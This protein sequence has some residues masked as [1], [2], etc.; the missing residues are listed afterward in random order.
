MATK[1]YAVTGIL[2]NGDDTFTTVPGLVLTR[3]EVRAAIIGGP[4]LTD[5]QMALGGWDHLV[6]AEC[7]ET[8]EWCPELK[9]ALA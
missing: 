3:A 6:C 1:S 5:G 4:R 7:D 2:A 8:E 9:R